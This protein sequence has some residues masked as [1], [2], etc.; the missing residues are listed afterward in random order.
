[1]DTLLKAFREQAK[2][3]IEENL[4]IRSVVWDRDG[5]RYIIVNWKNV[6][7]TKFNINPTETFEIQTD[8]VI[9]YFMAN[10]YQF[11]GNIKPL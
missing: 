5:K 8:K 11:I 6:N 2:Q 9:D 7:V 1:M 4:M 3:W 10:N